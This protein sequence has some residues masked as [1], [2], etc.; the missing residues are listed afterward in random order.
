MTAVETFYRTGIS[1]LA[2]RGRSISK[3]LATGQKRKVNFV[4]R[5]PYQYT[6]DNNVDVMGIF[7]LLHENL[8]KNFSKHYNYRWQKMS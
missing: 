7:H 8:S 3:H 1:E 5:R 2:I 6:Q 4:S